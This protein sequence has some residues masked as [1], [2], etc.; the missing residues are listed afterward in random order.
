MWTDDWVNQCKGSK[1]AGSQMIIVRPHPIIHHVQP[2]NN[3]VET[4]WDPWPMGPDWEED[5]EEAFEG[6]W[7]KVGNIWRS[8]EK[9]GL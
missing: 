4:W 9:Q 3:G 2:L 8:R 5:E 7:V 1:N 6:E